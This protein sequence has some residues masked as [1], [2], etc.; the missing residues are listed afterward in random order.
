[1][2]KHCHILARTLATFVATKIFMYM[3]SI[4]LSKV[5]ASIADASAGV[6]SQPIIWRIVLC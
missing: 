2:R 3:I 1:M 4:M 5:I 6:L